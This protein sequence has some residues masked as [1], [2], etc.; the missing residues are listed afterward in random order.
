MLFEEATH[1]FSIF[2]FFSSAFTQISRPCSLP[3]L[4]QDAAAPQMEAQQ[5]RRMRA[6]PR[7]VL[8]RQEEA[9]PGLLPPPPPLPLSPLPLPPSLP[10]GEEGELLR[11]ALLPLPHQQQ[12]RQELPP[13][14]SGQKQQQHQWLQ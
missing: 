6:L 11:P 4:P 1:L 12:Q 7:L 10:E 14:P 13:P 8:P 9:R 5:Q 2:H 3:L